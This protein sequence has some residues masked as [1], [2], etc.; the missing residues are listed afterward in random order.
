M[1]HL[2]RVA[3]EKPDIYLGDGWRGMDSGAFRDE[4]SGLSN[5][6][7]WSQDY[8]GRMYGKPVGYGMGS[9]EFDACKELWG[10]EKK[11]AAGFVADQYAWAGEHG[12][13]A[14]WFGITRH[15]H[16]GGCREGRFW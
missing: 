7:Q 6:G 13:T 5:M 1:R 8:L 14:F 4:L 3:M 12:P 11:N 2:C 10:V 16:E 15:R 9:M